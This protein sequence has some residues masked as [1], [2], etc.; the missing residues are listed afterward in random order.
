M[1]GGGQPQDQSQGQG[2]P[3][4]APGQMTT[5]QLLSPAQGAS[6]PGVPAQGGGDVNNPGNIRPAGSS[7]GFNSYPTMGAGVDALSHNLDAYAKQGWTSVNDI[8]SH[9]APS[10][11]NDTKTLIANAAKRLGVDPNAKLDL[12]DSNTKA[13]VAVAIMQQEN[14]G[15]KLLQAGGQG[16]GQDQGTSPWMTGTLPPQA[17][18]YLSGKGPVNDYQE[19]LTARQ[20]T[21]HQTAYTISEMQKA[22]PYFTAGLGSPERLEAA[23]ALKVL[24]LDG[25]ADKIMGSTG[26]GVAAAQ[27]FMKLAIPQAITQMTQA[28]PGGRPNQ[29]L[30]SA[31]MKNNPTISTD[32][33]A[34][35]KIFDFYTHVMDLHD[36]E[37]MAFGK[38]VQAEQGTGFKNGLS[39]QNFTDYWQDQLKRNGAL[40][41]G[42]AIGY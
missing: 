40:D 23:R 41:F 1:N 19:M 9:W 39:L 6:A 5:Q 15:P 12:S 36:R 31:F 32:P 4:T 33:Q 24:G 37:K 3:G 35:Q 22:L 27:E 25:A 20:N 13:Q 28:A 34:I 38:W 16:Q 8:V 17:A 14:G 7:T 11:E 29:M 30:E 26:G 42:K 21:D 10:S 18:D 2:V